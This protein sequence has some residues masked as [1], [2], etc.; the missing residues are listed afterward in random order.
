MIQEWASAPV[1]EAFASPLNTLAGKGCCLVD[2]QELEQVVILWVCE[3]RVSVLWQLTLTYF[4]FLS[5]NPGYHS[6]FADV[7]GL[8]GSLGSFFESSISDGTVEVNP[9][10]DEDVVLRTATFCQTCPWGQCSARLP[11]Y[12]NAKRKQAPEAP[13]STQ[14]NVTV[15]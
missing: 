15:P 14:S 6:A 10:F 7:D 8:F 11:T 1:I 13:T 4:A 9:P 5:I 3:T 12:M 2:V